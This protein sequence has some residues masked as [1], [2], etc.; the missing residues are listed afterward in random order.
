MEEFL[1]DLEEGEEEQDIDIVAQDWIQHILQYHHLFL[2]STVYIKL[3]VDAG[4]KHHQAQ[5]Q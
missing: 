3:R 5:I 4:I 2:V 1:Q